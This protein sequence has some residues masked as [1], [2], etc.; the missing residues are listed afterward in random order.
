MAI[1]SAV[2]HYQ[3]LAADFAVPEKFVVFM[4]HFQPERTT[5]PEGYRYAQQLFALREISD[6]LPSGWKLLV[7]DHPS[8]FRNRFVPAVRSN[9]FYEAIAGMENTV[10]V[11]LA[12]DPFEL[13]DK[14]EAVATI[15]GTVGLESIVRGTPAVVFG[16]AQYRAA[17][18][19]IE[20]DSEPGLKENLRNMDSFRSE[21]PD[22]AIEKYLDWVWLNSFRKQPE[23][24]GSV[25]AVKTAMEIVSSNI[26]IG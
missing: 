21:R 23:I 5:L 9:K 15:T 20:A 3:R 26:G 11:P 10:L 25:D 1:Y 19:V 18:G 17:P 12:T 14:A 13:I 4:L 16:A 8:I 24:N 6:A 7:K 22:E 2:N